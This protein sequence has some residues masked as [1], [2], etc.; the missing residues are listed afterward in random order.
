[1]TRYDI[2]VDSIIKDL[3]EIRD[4]WRED[5]V[6]LFL[7]GMPVTRLTEYQYDRAFQDALSI[8]LNRVKAA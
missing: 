2:V 1:M 3:T 8:L 4:R 6:S 5:E 7:S